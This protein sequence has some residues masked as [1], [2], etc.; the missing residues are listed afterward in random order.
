MVRLQEECFGPVL[1]LIRV[2]DTDEAVKRANASTYGLGASIWCGDARSGRR[3]A[4]E[5]EVGMV[6]I[7]DVNIAFPQAPWGGLKRSGNGYELSTDA[8]F[9]YGRRKHISV[10]LGEDPTRAW[11]YPYG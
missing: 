9:E 4:N 7:N 2:H 6:W 11:W 3:L 5:L 10:D 1:P 8:V